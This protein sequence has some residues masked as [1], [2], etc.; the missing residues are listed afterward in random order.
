MKARL[1]YIGAFMGCWLT[2]VANATTYNVTFNN[3]LIDSNSSY[4]ITGSFLFNDT[5][6]Q[7]PFNQYG[8]SNFN[9]LAVTPYGTFHMNTVWSSDSNFDYLG[10]GI[11]HA[12]DTPALMLIFSNGIFTGL[13]ILSHAAQ[14]GLP[15]QFISNGQ[16][17]FIP[18]RSVVVPSI[19]ALYAINYSG[20][21][22]WPTVFPS[23]SG[24][25]VPAPVPVPNIGAGLPG[26]IL[27]I[28]GF[29]AWWRR[30]QPR[31]SP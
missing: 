17:T 21:G 28:G 16:T 19:A 9:V 14:N 25:L 18:G 11:S 22:N 30:R 3:V 31:I 4:P 7:D 20:D 6:A 5:Q 1:S 8:L 2:S 15:I 27:A 24:S 12:S 26:L 29:V 23:V 10:L 13:N